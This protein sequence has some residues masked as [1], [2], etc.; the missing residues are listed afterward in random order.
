MK[1]IRPYPGHRGA[2][3]ARVAPRDPSG[4]NAQL[5]IAAAYNNPAPPWHG[6]S[7]LNAMQ[8][9]YG[10]W[11]PAG[12]Q[13]VNGPLLASAWVSAAPPESAG[14]TESPLS[15]SKALE[16]A[17]ARLLALARDLREKFSRSRAQTSPVPSLERR[18]E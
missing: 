16:E 18:D 15:V 11:L 9:A 7:A 8:N 6:N 5:Q 12:M 1:P 3:P 14:S 13:N 4:L 2:K 17:G 10:Q